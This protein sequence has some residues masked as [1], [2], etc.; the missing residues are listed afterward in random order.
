MNAALQWSVVVFTAFVLC[1]AHQNNLA[2][3]TALAL[4]GGDTSAECKLFLS[5][6]IGSARTF[7]TSA[8]IIRI[9]GGVLKFLASTRILTYEEAVDAN[10][11]F[12]TEPS[13]A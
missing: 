13:S 2:S 1:I 12:A 6:F 9:W 3:Q 7:S 11:P 8:Y 10:V 5:R 4:I